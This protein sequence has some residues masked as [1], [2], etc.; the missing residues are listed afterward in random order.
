MTFDP[1]QRTFTNERPRFRTE[2]RRNMTHY[3]LHHRLPWALLMGILRRVVQGTADAK[4]IR[5]LLLL[6]PDNTEDL[7]RRFAAAAHQCRLGC[8]LTLREQAAVSTVEIELHS[9]P[10]NL[11]QGL[12][13][14]ADDPGG[15]AMD[16][17]PADIAF[18][19]SRP[20]GPAG[21]MQ[22]CRERLFGILN[23]GDVNARDVQHACQQWRYLL[24][25]SGE[26]LNSATAHNPA[27][28]AP[29]GMPY[30]DPAYR[31][32]VDDEGTPLTVGQ[33]NRLNDI[34]SRRAMTRAAAA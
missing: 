25:R 20:E 24:L 11:F 27:W 9:L 3:T 14:R 19:G 32:W 13:N 2:G 15:C 33:C 31:H 10:C 6:S 12:S 4:I 23:R 17:T 28:W 22:Q 34:V 21:E 30:A 5:W 29:G 1:E 16:F 7:Y 26:G 18:D 8:E